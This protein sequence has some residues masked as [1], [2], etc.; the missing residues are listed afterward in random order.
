MLLLFRSVPPKAQKFQINFVEE[1]KTRSSNQIYSV[2]KL[3]H[4]R[5]NY[6]KYSKARHAMHDRRFA[7]Q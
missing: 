2:Q 6:E 4:L 1:I 5:H 7:C 3:C